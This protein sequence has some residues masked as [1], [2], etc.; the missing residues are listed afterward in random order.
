MVKLHMLEDHLVP[1]FR[2]W[3]GVFFLAS[4]QNKVLKQCT[5]SSTTWQGGLLICQMPPKA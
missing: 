3:Q 1:H 2:Q 5:A 4:C